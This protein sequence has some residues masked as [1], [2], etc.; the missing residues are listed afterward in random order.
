MH[1]QDRAPAPGP[2]PDETAMPLEQALAVY[3]ERTE[4][5]RQVRRAGQ[6]GT[7]GLSMR[8]AA[9]AKMNDAVL[10]HQDAWAA[11]LRGT[12]QER[13]AARERLV[14]AQ[15]RL[16]ACYTVAGEFYRPGSATRTAMVD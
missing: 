5:R 7:V 10:G 13:E 16:A 9:I 3:A 11:T 1:N 4:Q 14:V 12:P 2:A 6:G 15:R 8:Q